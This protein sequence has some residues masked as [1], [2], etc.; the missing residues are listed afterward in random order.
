MSK[1]YVNTLCLISLIFVIVVLIIISF[2]Y[3]QWKD[4]VKF[5]K[6]SNKNE[7]FLVQNNKQEPEWIGKEV[8]NRLSRLVAKVDILVKNMIETSYPSKEIS[9]RL[10]HRWQNIRK[11]PNGL[12]ETAHHETSAAY[13]VN[14]GQEVRICVRNKNSNKIFEDENTMMFVMLHELGHIASIS[15]G[16]NKEFRDNFRHLTVKAIDLKLYAYEDFQNSPTTYCNTHINNSS[17]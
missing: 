5:V 3:Y 12:R 7:G 1:L 14:K 4:R 10:Y 17:I 6:S 2:S 9:Q 15:Y 13:S 16:H 8:S 11:N